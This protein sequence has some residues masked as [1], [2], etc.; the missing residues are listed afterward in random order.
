MA[1]KIITNFVFADALHLVRGREGKHGVHFI[2]SVAYRAMFDIDIDIDGVTKSVTK[3]ITVP[4]GFA[5]DFASIP[6]MFQGIVQK[7]GPHIE[8][9]VVHDYLCVDKPWTSKV[10]AD[11]FYA[12]MLAGGTPKRLAWVMWKAVCWGGPRW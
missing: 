2:L 9:A 6:R 3:T 12:G 11:V 1:N 8:A 5:T 7:L 10:A 4:P